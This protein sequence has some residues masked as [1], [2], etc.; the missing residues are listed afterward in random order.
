MY[1]IEDL[2]TGGPK[3]EKWDS[4]KQLTSILGENDGIAKTRELF[5]IELKTY[6]RFQKNC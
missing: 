1:K 2:V 3:T 4:S 5:D 6:L